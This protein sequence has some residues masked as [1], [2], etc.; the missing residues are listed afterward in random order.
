MTSMATDALSGPQVA[1]LSHEID[2]TVAL[3]RHGRLALRELN[4]VT[5]DSSVVFVCLSSGPE[6]LLKLSLGLLSLEQTGMWPSKQQMMKSWATTSSRWTDWHSTKSRHV[7]NSAAP[8]RISK[9][10]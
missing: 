9:R 6:K 3:F 5:A 7:E 10:C 1:A 2:D 8:R 4:F